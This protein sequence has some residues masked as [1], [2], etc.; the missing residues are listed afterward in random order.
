MQ[1]IRNL[2]KEG[3]CCCWVLFVNLFV[4]LFY[5][6]Y[7][8]CSPTERQQISGE[9]GGKQLKLEGKRRCL[10]GIFRNNYRKMFSCL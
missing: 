5:T 2:E 3:D 4:C 1:E 6:G 9:G 8:V 7:E 10:E